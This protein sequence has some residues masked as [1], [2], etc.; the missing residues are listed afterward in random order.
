MLMQITMNTFYSVSGK[1]F[2]VDQTLRKPFLVAEFKTRYY[3]D[4][5]GCCQH[6]NRLYNDRLRRGGASF[7]IPSQ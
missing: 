7:A 4:L 6:C 2:C 5:N 3:A 1:F